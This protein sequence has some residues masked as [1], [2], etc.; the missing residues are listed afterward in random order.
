MAGWSCPDREV[1]EWEGTIKARNGFE[2]DGSRLTNIQNENIEDGDAQGQMAF[3]DHDVANLKWKHTET[4]ELF[5]DDTNKFLGI[6]T[7]AP[8]EILELANND[9]PTLAIHNTI[10]D[11]GGGTGAADITFKREQ[12]G[13]EISICAAIRGDHSGGLDDQKGKLR[14]FTNDGDDGF[15]PTERMRIDELGYVGVNDTAYTK[16]FNVKDNV[17]STFVRFFNDGN[18][19]NRYG[20]VIVAGADNGSG[21]TTYISATDG[22]GTAT[23]KIWTESGV[24]KL[25]DLSDE[26]LKENI[27]DTK[28]NGLDIINNIKVR[29][30]AFKHTPEKTRTG[31]I[32][33]ELQEVY[34]EAVSEMVS[35]EFEGKIAETRLGECKTDLIVPLV[36]AIQELKAEIELLKKG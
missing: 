11:D 7:S 18:N 31:F 3:W 34:P 36:K 5:W 13:G 28:I 20:I 32:A 12:S 22:N 26:R 21:D 2:G 29:D 19:E 33:Q 27:I 35:E 9:V 23:G 30:F 17:A 8:A 6:G 16:R 1:I 24:F 10:E 15:A 25:T 14:F 4:S